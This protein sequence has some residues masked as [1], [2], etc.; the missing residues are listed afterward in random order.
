VV[1]AE[2]LFEWDEANV[3]HIARH[4]YEPDEVEEVF[5]GGFKIR[6]GRKSSYLCYGRTLDGRLAFIV[7]KRLGKRI[8]VAT[9]RDMEDK[10]RRMY[11]KK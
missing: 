2:I 1:V 10:E 5:E 11:L 9:A 4:G 8:R 6:K 7:F 3:E